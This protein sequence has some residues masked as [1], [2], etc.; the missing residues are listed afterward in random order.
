M[1]E[2]HRIKWGARQGKV[3]IRPSKSVFH[4]RII[5]AALAKGTSSFDLNGFA[6]NQDNALTVAAVEKLGLARCTLENDHLQIEGGLAEQLVVP[7]IECGGSASTLRF[8]LPLALLKCHGARFW[9]EKRLFERPL[10]PY[11]DLFYQH[12]AV[13]KQGERDLLIGGELYPG[14]YRLPGN[15]SSQFASGLLFALPLLDGTSELFFTETMQ[16]LPY[17]EMTLDVLSQAGIHYQMVP[18]AR[19][20]VIPGGQAYRVITEPVEGDYSH[21]AFF[22]AAGALG[23]PVE[24][25]GLNPQSKQGD[26]FMLDLLRRYGA[27]VDTGPDGVRVCCQDR[28]PLECDMRQIPDLFPVLAVLACG[29]EGKS[30][31]Y[32]AERLRGKEN[33]R[34]SAMANGLR[35]L[36]AEVTELPDELQI[37]GKGKLWGGYVE[38]PRDH[39]VAMALAV[40]AGISE[41][42]IEISDGA[43][44]ER[45]APEFWQQYENLLIFRP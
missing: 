13:V 5:T 33:D 45:F 12:Y 19:H 44:V 7:N 6:I 41:E 3:D 16:S 32:H 10:A 26:R 37:W 14:E 8:L 20:I 1:L 11:V 31:L 21:A 27:K 36:G 40:A 43:C 28:R 39:R 38:V 9:G 17:M 29:A 2:N 18:E 24:V 23:G 30:R 22:L 34:L 15:V 42:E 25:R 35:C 4:R